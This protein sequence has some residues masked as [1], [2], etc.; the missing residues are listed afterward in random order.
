MHR[1]QSLGL[2]LLLVVFALYVLIRVR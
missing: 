1:S 2:V